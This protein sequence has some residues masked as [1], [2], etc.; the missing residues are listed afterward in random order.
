MSEC[1]QIASPNFIQKLSID[2]SGV[3]T[4]LLLRLTAMNSWIFSRSPFEWARKRLSVSLSYHK[5]AT[6]VLTEDNSA[7]GSPSKF[8]VNQIIPRRAW[9]KSSEGEGETTKAIASPLVVCLRECK[10][11][12]HTK[13]TCSAYKREEIVFRGRQAKSHRR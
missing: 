9:P 5:K 4:R 3:W 7:L 2:S 6:N 1:Q 11:T 10:L 8:R 13:A 12:P